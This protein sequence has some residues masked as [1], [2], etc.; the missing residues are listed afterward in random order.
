MHLI[1]EIYNPDLA[2]LPIGNQVV[3]SPLE[4]AHA[5]RLL[6]VEHVVPIH[7]GTFPFLPGTSE[8][9]QE[10]VSAL[11]PDLKVH[12]MKPGEELSS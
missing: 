4:A 7:Y 6:G 8:E 9:F 11:V 1:G 3:M 12:V 2:L 10:H 5:A